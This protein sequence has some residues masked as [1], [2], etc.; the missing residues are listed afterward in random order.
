MNPEKTESVREYIDESGWRQQQATLRVELD[1]YLPK[2]IRKGTSAM[3][4]YF[5]ESNNDKTC[6][7]WEF[8]DEMSGIIDRSHMLL[9]QPSTFCYIEPKAM[10]CSKM[11]EKVEVNTDSDVGSH[12][13]NLPN[14]LHTV[15]WR[16][17]SPRFS[18]SALKI[19]NVIPSI[20]LS[21]HSRDE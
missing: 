6:F 9:Y 11:R 2:N 15:S 7:G 20:A 14:S 10:Q 17:G 18:W 21:R 3:L 13:E 5:S 12:V 16:F 4:K 8:Y 1:P 19:N